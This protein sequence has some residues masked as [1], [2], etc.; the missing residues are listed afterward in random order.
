[1]IYAEGAA[2]ETLLTVDENA[3][4]FADY[5]RR[6]GTPQSEGQRCAPILSIDG[7]R[8][9]IKSRFRSAISPWLDRRHPV[10]VIR[11]RL[12]ERALDLAPRVRT[13]S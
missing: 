8:A 1:M 2:S 4:N 13:V 9:Q 5:Y 7:G 6:Y 12:E 10:D 11:D 3:N